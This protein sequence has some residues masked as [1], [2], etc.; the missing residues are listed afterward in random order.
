VTDIRFSRIFAI[1]AATTLVV[2]ALV[3]L[4]AVVTG[5]FSDADGRILISLAG[6]LYVGGTLLSGVALIDR[7]PAPWLGWA[8]VGAAP[9]ALAFVLAAVW[10]WVGESGNED[11]DRLAWSSV[12]VLLTGLMATTS[13]LLARRARITRLASGA[14]ALAAIAAV[15]SLFALWTGNSGDALVKSIAVFWILSAL[16]YF[17]VPI[18][19]RFSPPAA[20]SA[21][22]KLAALGDVELVATRAREGLEIRL[23]PGERVVLRRRR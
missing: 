21:D 15:L 19:E 1:G 6:L 10:E 4:V 3:A 17:L 18:L 23:A 16:A 22:R 12:L 7:G 5:D 8:V 2:A 13:L 9:V 11:L 14:G 20:A